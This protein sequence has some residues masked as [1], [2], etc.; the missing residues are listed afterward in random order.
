[1]V[2]ED[3]QSALTPNRETCDW[4]LGREVEQT[5]AYGKQTLFLPKLLTVHVIE[6]CLPKHCEHIHFGANKSIPSEGLN[7][8]KWALLEATITKFLKDDLWCTLDVP[9]EQYQTVLES[10]LVRYNRFILVVN[11][12][13]PRIRQAGY[14]AVLKIDDPSSGGV[15]CHSLHDLQD[16]KKFTVSD[17]YKHDKTY[18]FLK[19]TIEE[20][21]R[22]FNDDNSN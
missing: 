5:P 20:I 4:F 15:W 11:L 16:R 22:S 7:Q 21:K 1:M 19:P 2:N 14:N 18:R 3:L 9:A 12:E 8:S 17:E 13:L 6:K 10:S